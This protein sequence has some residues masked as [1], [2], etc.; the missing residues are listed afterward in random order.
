MLFAGILV[1]L[2]AIP[3]VRH[4]CI[5]NLLPLL[6]LS[7]LIAWA[8]RHFRERMIL[9]GILGVASLLHVR[10]IMV[11]PIEIIPDSEGYLHWARTFADGQGFPGMIYRRPVYPMLLGAMFKAGATTLLPAVTAQHLL[12]LAS[13]G[14]LYFLGRELSFSKNASFLAVALFSLNSL[15]MQIAQAI[16]VESLFVFLALATTLML[17]RFYRSGTV[18]YAVL[19]GLGASMMSLTRGFG[20]ILLVPFLALVVVRTRARRLKVITISLGVVLFLTIPWSVRNKV[21]YDHFGLSASTGLVVFTHALSYRIFDPATENGSILAPTLSHVIEDLDRDEIVGK[22]SPEDDWQLNAIPHIL[23]D[24][25]V[26]HHGMSFVEADRLLLRASIQSILSSPIKY[27]AGVARSLRAMIFEHRE[28]YPNPE[29]IV[30]LGPLH[31]NQFI[32]RF[33]RGLVYLP[34][35]LFLAFPFVYFFRNSGWEQCFPFLIAAGGLCATAAIQ[36]GF[37]RYTIPWIGFQVLCVAGLLETIRSQ[38]S[39]RV[40]RE[41]PNI[42]G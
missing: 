8:T 22:Q 20:L 3:S 1:V 40:R 2:C 39:R 4:L 17:V 27:A 11:L 21:K 26:Q 29:A 41:F 12:L 28:M 18:G 7:V 16:L 19:S 15:M 24:S 13:S 9:L 31:S 37:T 42:G 25:L 36:V 32:V 23:V 33:M 35:I 30:P 38:V 5:F 10:A 14:V 6:F 34:G